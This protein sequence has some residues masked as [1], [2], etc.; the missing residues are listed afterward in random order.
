[1]NRHAVSRFSSEIVRPM[2]DFGEIVKKLIETL[3]KL[4]SSSVFGIFRSRKRL[5]IHFWVF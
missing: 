2:L 5:V 4:I 1:M 3:G